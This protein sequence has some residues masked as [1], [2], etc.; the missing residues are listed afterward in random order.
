[1]QAHGCAVSLTGGIVA[2]LLLVGA[3]LLVD[4]LGC[5]QAA[6][7]AKQAQYQHLCCPATALYV[8]ENEHTVYRVATLGP[9]HGHRVLTSQSTPEEQPSQRGAV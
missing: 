8:T 7:S 9:Y 5:V 3:L 2:L 6:E 1:L 4:F